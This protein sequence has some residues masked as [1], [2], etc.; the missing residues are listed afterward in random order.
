MPSE[1]HKTVYLALGANAA[2][3]VAK[4]AGGAISGSTAMLAEGAHSVADTTNQLFLLASLN[5]SARKPDDDHPFGY[6]KERFFWSFLAAVFIFVSGALFSIYMGVNRMLSGDK[7]ESSVGVAFAVLALG[8]VLEGS[9]LL[10][11]VRQ[12]KADATRRQ[13]AFRRH[14]RVSRDPTTKTVVFEDTAA[15]IG[16]A[17][18]AL[19]LGLSTIT[20]NSVYDGAASVAIGLVLAV[21]A[22]FLGRDTK[23]LLIGEAALPEERE[24]LTRVFEDHEDVDELIEMLTMALGPDSLL[25]AAKFDPASHLSSDDVENLASELERQLHDA[26]PEVQ[27][28]FLDPTR[29]RVAKSSTAS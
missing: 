14:V 23:A 10:R 11:A 15:L 19:G 17:L 13:R 1:S 8:V 2:I 26:V 12:T 28:V 25:L 6:G 9:S 29:R 21:I 5:L 7:P 4:F 18:A 20:E 27:Q 24:A 22:F 3:G 16:I